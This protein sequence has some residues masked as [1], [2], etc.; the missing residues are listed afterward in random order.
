MASP[1]PSTAAETA[2]T[3]PPEGC[4]GMDDDC[5][6]RVDEGTECSSGEI[7]SCP[8]SCGSTG[9]QT[10]GGTCT[11]GACVPPTEL[12]NGV[13]DDCNGACDDGVGSCCAGSTA[14][15]ASLGMG[16][17]SGMATCRSDCSGYDTSTCTLC[18]NGTI[19]GS[20]QCDDPDYGGA[21]CGSVMSGTSGTL[22]CTSLCTYDVSMCRAFNPNG[23]YGTS[24][25]PDYMCA[26]YLGLVYLVDYTITTFTIAVSGS[27]ITVSGAPCAMMG[28][29]TAATRSFTASCT[30]TGAC[31]ET[32]SLSGM[33]TADDQWMGSF[34]ADFTPMSLGDCYDC[35]DQSYPVTATRL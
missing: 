31:D 18:G 20:E 16:F 28:T 29:Y 17:S 4:T 1:A 14:D 15:C 11:Y 30:L 6:G 27:S 32:Y 10:C 2:N 24:T 26:S 12:C 22:G 35:A 8:T 33:F 3:A 13:D 19:D 7:R 23:D 25:P 34:T 5:D 9:T 21:T